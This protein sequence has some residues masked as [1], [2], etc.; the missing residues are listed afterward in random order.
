[1]YRKCQTMKND[2][3]KYVI[4]TFTVQLNRGQLTGWRHLIDINISEDMSARHL[5]LLTPAHRPQ[6][7]DIYWSFN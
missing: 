4:Q 6:A 2:S 7:A 1:M 3:Y 5:L